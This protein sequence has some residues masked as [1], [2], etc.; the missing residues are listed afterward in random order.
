M[1]S[2]RKAAIKS[3]IS[4]PETKYLIGL[5]RLPLALFLMPCFQMLIVSGCGGGA[6]TSIPPPVVSIAISPTSGSVQVGLTLQF[7]ASVSGTSNTAVTWQTNGVTGGAASTGTISTSGL[8]TAP[9]AVPTTNTVTVTAT[10]AADTTKNASATVTI[11][12][13]P[14]S[15]TISPTAASVVTLHT[16]QFAATVSNTTNIAVTWSV[17]GTTGGLAAA[18]TISASGLYIAPSVVPSSPVVTVTATSSADTTKSASAQVTVQPPPVPMGTWSAIGP[19]GITDS[20]NLATDPNNSEMIYAAPIHGGLYKTINLGQSWSLLPTANPSASFNPVVAPAS[21]T[22]YALARNFYQTSTDGATTFS[23]TA[24]YPGNLDSETN[25]GFTFAVDP[26]NDQI[27]YILTS[28]ALFRSSNGGSTWTSLTAPTSPFLVNNLPLPVL[29]TLS[30]SSE[31]S[32]ILFCAST[33]GF[34]ISKDGGMTWQF[35]NTGLDPSYLFLR[36]VIQDPINPSHILAFG[37][38]SGTADPTPL[39][40]VYQSTDGGSSWAHIGTFGVYDQLAP[41]QTG[42]GIFVVSSGLYATFDSG[43]TWTNIAPS[44]DPSGYTAVVST[45]SPMVI[46]Y[47]GWDDLFVSKDGGVTW[48][49]SETGINARLIGQVMYAGKTGPLYAALPQATFIDG[50]DSYSTQMWRASDPGQPWTSIIDA[51]SA[52]PIVLFDADPQTPLQ[53]LGVEQHPNSGATSALSNNGGS[54]WT[55]IPYAVGMDDHGFPL[56]DYSG[57]RFGA[58]GSNMAYACGAFGIARISLLSNAWTIINDG[59]TSGAACTAIG[60]DQ[61]TSGILYADTTSGVY[62]TTDGGNSWTL[63]FADSGSYASIIVDPT[64]S[65]NVYLSAAAVGVPDASSSMRSIDGGNTWTPML[66]D[67]QMAIHPTD[68]NILYA[69]TPY[70]LA[71]SYDSGLTWGKTNAPYISFQDLT[72]T[73]S[74]IVVISTFGSSIVTFTP[75]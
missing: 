37:T 30:V 49:I 36:Q 74:G 34:E 68:P 63:L 1:M 61:F 71:V 73:P 51:Y 25:G 59:I 33:A 9:S 18:G 24:N 16:Q 2:F 8:Y 19:W 56:F 10:S 3:E 42:P 38:Y 23:A 45:I 6:S 67:G 54:T 32:S 47:E 40:Y 20:V 15:I 27:I 55:S 22:L 17:N 4:L 62:K 52:I 58:S 46:A 29:Q 11:I 48:T 53:I 44:S 66:A 26:Q 39:S 5:G 57:V 7:S 12:P 21:G 70:T 60:V 14:V 72:V 50:N 31:S 64:N 65:Q 41:T 35:Q 43:S 75:Q 69:I 28:T 13:P